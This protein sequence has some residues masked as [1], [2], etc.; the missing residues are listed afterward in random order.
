MKRTVKALI[1]LAVLAFSGVAYAQPIELFTDQL[2]KLKFT[3][4]ENVIQGTNEGNDLTAI[5][6]GDSIV[7]VLNVTSINNFSSSAD[8]NPQ[9][10]TSELTGAFQISVV[11]GY[12]P[13]ALIAQVGHL[14]FALTGTD[15]LKL[16]VGTG[17]T[18]NW[19]TTVA[20]ATDGDPWLAV[21]TAS[22]YYEGVSDTVSII[23]DTVNKNW[24]N[25]DP[26]ANNTGYII[27]PQSYATTAGENTVHY[28]DV[29]NN[30]V[31][32]IG[33][34]TIEGDHFVDLFFASRLFINTDPLV[35]DW[36]FRSEDPLYL[37]A[38]AV[39]EPSTLLL[40]GAGL[41]G[42]GLTARRRAKK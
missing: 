20:N 41:V 7:G 36:T 17:A 15:Y 35:P 19:D 11:G 33:I 8:L 3:N 31:L 37:Y 38:T 2:N 9:L 23:S 27:V 22:T 24:A 6:T 39:P 34:D 42:L 18:K 14:D 32:D 10:Q 30:G 4:Y 28:K 21:T 13:I 12:Q 26:G 5:D 40:L 1:T 16:F 29:N 25:I